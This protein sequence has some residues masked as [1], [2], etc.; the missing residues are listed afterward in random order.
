MMELLTELPMVAISRSRLIPSEDKCDRSLRIEPCRK[1]TPTSTA[2][3]L[4]QVDSSMLRRLMLPETPGEDARSRSR[5][6]HDK[7]RPASRT[8]ILESGRIVKFKKLA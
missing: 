1:A 6:A 7:H 4:I 5:R 8:F 2:N 3:E